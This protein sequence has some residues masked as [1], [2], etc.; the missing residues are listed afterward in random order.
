M[1]VYG[2]F[3]QRFER[4]PRWSMMTSFWS[5][6]VMLVITSALVIWKVDKSIWVEL[7]IITMA[8][9]S[10]MWLYFTIIL[11]VGVHFDSRRHVV[12]NWPQGQPSDYFDAL[13]VSNSGFFTEAGAE[14]G[15]IGIVIGFILD[16]VVAILLVFVISFLLWL[17][18]NAV[19]ALFIPLYWF[20]RRS[21]RYLI[22]KGRNC[23]GRVAASVMHGF[24][25]AMLYTVWF[26]LIFYSAHLVSER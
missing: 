8:V 7:E 10:L 24:S 4:R 26:Y 23:R 11:Y 18:V 17:G 2:D 3:K 1:T 22:T 15:V 21:L 19:I 16:V 6:V 5:S 9:A 25:T 14:A 13:Y 20:H 12:M